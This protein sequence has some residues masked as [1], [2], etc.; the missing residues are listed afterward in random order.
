M[1]DQ[2]TT[3]TVEKAADLLG[4]AEFPRFV[5]LLHDHWQEVA[6]NKEIMKLD[7]IYERYL[8]LDKEGKLHIVVA[9]EAGVIVGY[10]IHF[11][12]RTHMHYRDLFCAEDDIHYMIPRL[13]KTGLHEAMRQF[14]LADMKAR[15][16]QWVTA[17]TKLDHGHDNAL[18][19]LG[20]R[21]LD[22]VYC[23]D[24]TKWQPS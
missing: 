14:A 1:R 12:G 4:P 15:G 6:A 5:E 7:P 13:R 11:C 2:A 19:R 18:R 16:V 10:S 21:P 3:F 24:L 9:R 23:L 22:Q 17:R 8:K 20:F